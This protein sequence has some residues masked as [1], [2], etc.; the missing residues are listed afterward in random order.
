MNNPDYEDDFDFN[1]A[2]DIEW[3]NALN[4]FPFENPR[5]QQI[6]VVKQIIDAVKAGKTDIIIQAPTGVGKSG[7]ALAL[8]RVADS[9]I[10]TAN[11]DL[12][13]Q[14]ASEFPEYL[15][16]MMG[17]A[18]YQC[19]NEVNEVAGVFPNCQ[20]RCAEDDAAGKACAAFNKKRPKCGYHVQLEK[21]LVA[22]CT[23]FNFAAYL[24]FLNYSQFGYR[25][26]TIFDE[27]HN[28]PHWLTNFLGVTI[29][30]YALKQLKLD[31]D[32][33]FGRPEFPENMSDV[34]HYIEALQVAVDEKKLKIKPL[35]LAEKRNKEVGTKNQALLE[36][37]NL[38]AD[39]IESILD[40]SD[41]FAIT[42]R[43]Q[44]NWA[45]EFKPIRVD[46]SSEDCLLRHSDIRIYLSATILD[47]KSFS[48]ILGLDPA[49]TT[50][51]EIPSDFSPAKRPIKPCYIGKLNR[52]T[53]DSLIPAM[54][55]QITEI[56]N[57]HNMEKGIIHGISYQL[58]NKIFESL[59]NNIQRRIIYPRSTWQKEECFKKHSEVQFG[60]ILLSPSMSEGVDLR[61]DLA[62]FAIIPKIPWPSLGD[63]VV[64]A[65]MKIYPKYY[66][67]QTALT[68][69]Q[70]YGRIIRS[71]DD[72]GATYILDSM[73]VNF[74]SKNRSILPKFFLEGLDAVNGFGRGI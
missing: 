60:S 12:Q 15:E 65:R 7:I 35:V 28:I 29:S 24:T 41:N 52:T 67:I 21:A 71:K 4:L 18:N 27:A 33:N 26:I 34:R 10:A 74:L 69:V 70:M 36:K 63:P 14:Y 30:E 58:S 57:R 31:D 45:W 68:L 50:F 46:K 64:K 56:C 44:K 11:K 73:F 62:R 48:T 6:T 1:P 2:T 72:W 16:Q 55:A 49:K 19:V 37:V 51:M 9:Y 61:D 22:D 40:N 20:E 32:I 59:P 39:R 17:R 3:D 47:A 5:P 42:F 53:L 43:N 38:M 66:D 23:L 13:R 25:P 54:A 8:A